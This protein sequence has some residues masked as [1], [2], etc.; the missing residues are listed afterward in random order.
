MWSRRLALAL[1][2]LVGWTLTCARETDGV[3]DIDIVECAWLGWTLTFVRE[4]D[5][6]GDGCDIGYGGWFSFGVF[7]W[8]GP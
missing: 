4:T 3:G 7:G 1:A 2:C 5:S 8:D 6:G